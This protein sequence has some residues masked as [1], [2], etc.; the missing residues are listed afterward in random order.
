MQHIYY[1]YC[2]QQLIYVE[3]SNNVM[4][5]PKALQNRSD[6]TV[7]AAPFMGTPQEANHHVNKTIAEYQPKYNM[8]GREVIIRSDGSE[9]D[10]VTAAARDINVSTTQIYAHL[11]NQK[12]YRTVRGYTFKR[13]ITD[14]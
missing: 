3:K 2:E 6:Y 4:P 13:G 7:I 9:F 8:T 12:G 14:V 5:V 1:F 10:T 11:R